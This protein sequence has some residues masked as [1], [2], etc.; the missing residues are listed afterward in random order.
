MVTD[1]IENGHRLK[2]EREKRLDKFRGNQAQVPIVLQWIL[3][4]GT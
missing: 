4:M 1:V 2:S 3:P